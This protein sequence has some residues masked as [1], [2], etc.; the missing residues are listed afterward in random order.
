MSWRSQ[1]YKCEWV[2]HDHHQRA[3][4]EASDRSLPSLQ[5]EEMWVESAAMGAVIGRRGSLQHDLQVRWRLDSSSYLHTPPGNCLL[6]SP[7]LSWQSSS[8]TRLPNSHCLLALT[9][10][11]S[12]VTLFWCDWSRLPFHTA[13]AHMDTGATG[14]TWHMSMP[15][16]NVLLEGNL[17]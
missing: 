7:L 5:A 17:S 11:A 9:H 13:S 6:C 14:N 16:E 10:N 15:L 12:P 8:N 1:G 2:D 3:Q 4:R